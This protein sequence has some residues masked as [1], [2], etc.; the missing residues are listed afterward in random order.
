MLVTAV[1]KLVPMAM[2]AAMPAAETAV[3][4]MEPEPAASAR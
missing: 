4:M 2:A 1:S 3:V